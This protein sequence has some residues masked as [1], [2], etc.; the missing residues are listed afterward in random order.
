MSNKDVVLNVTY[1]LIRLQDFSIG[2]DSVSIVGSS[3]CTVP[4]YWS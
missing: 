1:L 3:P 4:S 2:R